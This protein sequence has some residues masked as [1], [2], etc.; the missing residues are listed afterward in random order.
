[1]KRALVVVALAM[2]AGV[3]TVTRADTPPSVWDCAKDP[4]VCE[5]YRLHLSVQ[6]AMHA[7]GADDRRTREPWLEVVRAELEMASAATSPDVRLRFDVGE[8]YE[9]LRHY[10]EAVRVLEPALA[11]APRHSAAPRAWLA[12]ASAAAHLDRSREERDAY[13]AY[14]AISLNEHFILE[15]L[16]NRAEAEMRLGNLDEAVAGYR[17]VIERIE[18]APF[19]PVEDFETLVMARWGLVVALDRSGDPADAAH[20]ASIVCQQDPDERIIGKTEDEGVFFRPEYERDWYLALGRTEHA[21]LA[22]DAREA[23]AKWNVV[24][25]TWADYVRR[26]TPDDRWLGL[27]RAHLASAEAKRDAAEARVQRL[28]KVR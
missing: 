7:P 19:G 23:Q 12:L 9:M 20:E 18:R 5:R 17:E 27:A 28:H 1:M 14:L 24:V 11:L 25:Q 2:L 16:G 13:D 8:V 15:V 21:R 22:T 6:K 10:E 4:A 26:A 3:S